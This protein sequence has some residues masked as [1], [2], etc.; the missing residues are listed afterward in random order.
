MSFLTFS[1]FLSLTSVSVFL[2]G[3]LPWPQACVG[4]LLL[5]CWG[6]GCYSPSLPITSYFFFEAKLKVHFLHEDLSMVFPLGFHSL[7]AGLMTGHIYHSTVSGS[8][9]GT[10]TSTSA[11]PGWPLCTV[12]LV[13]CCAKTPSWGLCPDQGCLCPEE[14]VS[15]PC[16]QC[17][18]R[19][20]LSK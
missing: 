5:S 18:Q 11:L 1:Y 13:A 9:C 4:R 12:V 17:I 15:L 14:R 7:M 8:V 20:L 6:E 3:Q 10:L 16:P 2:N 19:F